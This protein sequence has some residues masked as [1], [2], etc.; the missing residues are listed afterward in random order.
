MDSKRVFELCASGRPYEEVKAEL[1]GLM[2]PKAPLVARPAVAP[3]TVVAVLGLGAM[4][5]GVAACLEQYF[6]VRK[7]NRTARPEQN[8]PTVAAAC[9]GASV[10]FTMLAND[11][12]TRH[13]VCGEG[14]VL[15]SLAPGVIHVSLSTISVN[16]TGVL[17][18]LHAQRGQRYVACPVLGRP[19]AAGR[20][21]LYLLAGGEESAVREL[22]PVLEAFSQKC[23]VFATPA[24]AALVKLCCNFFILTTIEGLGEL[25]VLAE[26][27]G[28][29]NR[30]MLDTLVGTVFASPIVTR[31][32]A[33]L[34]DRAFTPVGFAIDLGLKDVRLVLEAGEHL[35]CPAPFAGVLR[36]RFLETLARPG[37]A[38]LDWSAIYLAVRAAAGLS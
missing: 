3:G 10:V 25:F 19:D 11:E 24:Q 32:G 38:E 1:E 31:Y 34:A 6:T 8:V 36:D 28:I 26:K 15:A 7:W 14:G 18:A 12:A 20:G 29:S 27:G 33:L 23:F 37:A 13:V 9:E 2:A 21:L 16:L 35:R 5:T 30:Q 22:R 4:G 17:S